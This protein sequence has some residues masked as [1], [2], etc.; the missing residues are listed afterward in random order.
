MKDTIRLGR[1]AG[2]QVGLHWSLLLIGGVLAADLA[3]RRFP[4]TAPGYSGPAYELAAGATAFLFLG[5]VLAHELGHAIVARREGIG[6]DGITLWFVGGVTR[7]TSDAA[8]PRAELSVSGAGP[9]VSFVLGVVMV[10]GGTA[11]HAGAVSPLLVAALTWLGV[12]NIVLAVFNVLPGAPLDG[13]RLLYAFVWSRHGDRRRA[14]RTASRAGEIL[15]ATLI[16]SGLLEFAFGAAAGG[17]LWIA[18]IG[19]FLLTGAR[20]EANAA[21]ARAVTIGSRPTSARTDATEWST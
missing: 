1:I 19:W 9:L 21:A 10:G 3:G 20:A 12:I 7:L 4:A 15:G 5:C 8:T 14:T 6:V 18:F 16:G 11:L 17:G 13:G 2:V